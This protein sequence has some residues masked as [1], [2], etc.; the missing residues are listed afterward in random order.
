MKN[1]LK[2]KEWNW[3]GAAATGWDNGYRIMPWMV[4]EVIEENPDVISINEF[5]VSDGWDYFR[6]KLIENDYC[7]FMT[8]TTYENGI[9]IALKKG[10]FD[11]KSRNDISVTKQ[12]KDK[13][14]ADSPDFL[15]ITVKYREHPLTIIGTRIKALINSNNYDEDFKYRKRQFELLVD[16]ISTVEGR[17][18]VMGDFNNGH[19]FNEFD[20]KYLYKNCARQYYNYQMIWRTLED[21]LKLSLSTPERGGKYG[22]KYSIVTMDYKSNKTYYTKEDHL[23]SRGFNTSK[24]DYIWDFVKQENGYGNKG[25]Y[26]YKGNIKFVPD[27]AILF[28]ELVVENNT[29]YE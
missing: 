16:Y 19:I 22:D 20:K 3:R 18:V 28:T 12:I 25:E 17:L 14:D 26:D 6:N 10:T 2:V 1:I 13:Y 23:I 4:N 29:D 8:Y 7:W 11:I 15:A 21:V 5:V 9:L 24:C 27:H